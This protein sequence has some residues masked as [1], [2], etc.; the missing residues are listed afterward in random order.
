MGSEA[1]MGGVQDKRMGEEQGKDRRETQGL[2]LPSLVQ[3]VAEGSSLVK[4]VAEISPLEPSAIAANAGYPRLDSV[5]SET[6]PTPLEPS[7][8]A[9]NAGYPRLDSVV[10]ETN[11]IN[12]PLSFLSVLQLSDTLERTGCVLAWT[13]LHVGH[14][15]DGVKDSSLW[16]V[17]F[18]SSERFRAG[19]KRLALPIREG[20]LAGLRDKLLKISLLEAAGED[21]AKKHAGDC[22][23]YLA[24]Y[25]CNT[26]VGRQKLLEQGRWIK[27]EAS[28]FQT[29]HQMTDRLLGHGT[30]EPVTLDA[31]EKDV[32]LARANYK[33]EEIGVCHKLTLRQIEPALPPKEHGGCIDLLKWVS[34]VTGRFLREP[35]LCILPDKGQKLPKLQGRIHVETGELDGITR[36]LVNR[37]VCDWTPLDQVLHF[38]G[39]PVLN[40][41]FGVPETSTIDSGEPILRVIMNLVPSNSVMLQL[42]GAVK[43]LPSITSWMSVVTEGKEEVRI[44]QS[45]MCNA[46]YLF[47]LPHQWRRCLSFNI[48]RWGNEIGKDPAVRYA[49]SCCVLPM[50]WLSSV[51]IM[52]EVSEQILLQGSSSEAEQ[53]V[54]NRAVPLWM[55]GLLKEAKRQN[56]SWWHVYLD[57]YA[58]GQIVDK[59]EETI[60]GERLH[61]L[62][63]TAWQKAQVVSSEKKRKRGVVEAEGLG[64]LVSGATNTIGG[65]PNR[66][67]RVIQATLWVLSRTHLSKKHVQVIAGRWIHI[68]QFR[69]PGMSFLEATWEYVGSKKFDL[70]L[71]LRVRR[72]LW[73]IVCATPFFQTNLGAT[74]SQVTTASD[75]SNTGGAVGIAYELSSEG[76]DFVAAS[77]SGMDAQAT[78]S[79]LV[80]SLFHGI[81]GSFRCYDIL[82][83]RP[84]GMV[85]FE[86]HGPANRVS[87]RR[88]P[89]A[90]QYGDVRTLD[91]VMVR[92]WLLKFV[93]IT[94]IHLWSGFPCTDLTSVKA[95]RQGLQGEQSKLFFE[96][97][98]IPKLLRKVA[99]GN[100]VVKFVGE[101]VASMGKPECEQ[102]S[103]ELETWPYH[104]NCADAV[105]M[106]RPRLCWCSEELE[107]ALE[108]LEFEPDTFW[109][110]LIAKAPYPEM[111]QWIE[112]GVYWP[113]GT[114]GE[115]LPTAMRAIIRSK[116]PRRDGKASISS[117]LHIIIKI[118]LCFGR[119]KSGDWQIAMSVN[120]SWDMDTSIL[121]SVLALAS[122]NSL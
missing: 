46:F 118:A 103:E 10:S 115:V 70:G 100:I 83:I 104:L 23:T 89:Q 55:V 30:Q 93:G 107:G 54:R 117:F 92:S 33:G 98:R 38:R 12:Q 2:V 29:V 5:V 14:R 37:G 34:P 105:P 58:G 4:A 53:V 15:E 21:F 17:L 3:A 114:Q 22:W 52:Q 39:E 112:P 72:E 1:R 57:N 20:E 68:L 66:L 97:P 62:A 106:N 31:I 27:A 64:A 65:S 59:G 91:E 86:I 11:P 95:F 8:I 9:A 116:P 25:A 36:V 119:V 102:I 51:A 24:C 67:L 40:G 13:L 82:G 99:G 32:K 73:A 75:A 41:L 74:V 76:Q 28:A 121:L 81:G 78:A 122:R 50:G 101:N 47:A 108:G 109:T 84:M 35:E 19:R 113:G 44:W 90:L 120:F 43:N 111:E 6:N 85:S 87:S 45:D 7:A 16:S 42:E 80:V 88:W 56:R 63:E 71:V 69:R 79:I 61:E 26:L 94:E 96:M 110:K 77:K 48:L 60:G 18:N 49:L